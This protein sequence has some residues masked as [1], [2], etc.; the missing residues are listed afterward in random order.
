[1]SGIDC[2]LSLPKTPSALPCHGLRHL[3]NLEPHVSIAGLSTKNYE[4]CLTLVGARILEM[5]P[6]VGDPIQ[7][8]DRIDGL[9]LTG[10]G[11]V[12]PALYGS[13]AEMGQLVD[14]QRDDFEIALIRGALEREQ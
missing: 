3:E 14:R 7:F 2:C 12:D 8:L 10:G 5:R 1:M 9:L 13:P 4:I 11:D 6:G